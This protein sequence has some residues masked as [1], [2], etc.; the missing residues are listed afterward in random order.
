LGALGAAPANHS[1]YFD[2]VASCTICHTSGGT[3]HITGAALHAAANL[4]SCRT[5]HGTNP[6]KFQ[7]IQTKNHESGECSR[8][9]CHAPGGNRGTA[10]IKWD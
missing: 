5:C 7:T 1:P 3:S 10:Y 6:M 2:G 9:G 8:S 4:T